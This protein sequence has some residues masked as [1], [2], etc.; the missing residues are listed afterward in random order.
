MPHVDL[1]RTDAKTFTALIYSTCKTAEFAQTD[2]RL[3]GGDDS[4]RSQIESI[5]LCSDQWTCQ[6][7]LHWAD[8]FKAFDDDA[9]RKGGVDTIQVTLEDTDV[10]LLYWLGANKEVQIEIC[11]WPPDF[12]G[13]HVWQET[14][15]PKVG[16]DTA[17]A[18]CERVFELVRNLMTAGR[19]RLLAIAAPGEF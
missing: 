7:G 3:T 5:L 14:R 16:M 11:L 10:Q 9:L 4:S 19:F 17:T 1:N 18:R 6:T 15:K 8:D 13:D 2:V 12:F